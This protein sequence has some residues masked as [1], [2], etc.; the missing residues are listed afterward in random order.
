MSGRKWTRPAGSSP[1]VRGARQVGR[2]LRGLIGIIPACA[3]STYVSTRYRL[4]A[5]DHPR[6]CGEHSTLPTTY[7][8]YEGSS[9]HVRGA[10]QCRGHQRTITGIIPACAGSTF[11]RWPLRCFARDHPR[12]CGEHPVE[13]DSRGVGLGSSPHVR[14]AHEGRMHSDSFVGIIPACAGSTAATASANRA[15]G[16]HPRMCGEHQRRKLV[17]S[18]Q[19]G[20]SPHVRGARLAER[21]RADDHGIIPACAGSTLFAWW[22]HRVTR[23]HPRMCGEHALGTRC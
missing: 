9:P 14:G 10:L 20:S 15:F 16:D 6:M 13:H 23:D 11:S 12:M 5:R 7:K 4:M 22:L 18:R 19:Q 2:H 1:H 21:A 17:S 3:G 8:A